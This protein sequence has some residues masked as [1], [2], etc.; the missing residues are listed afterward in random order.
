MRKVPVLAKG[1]KYAFGQ[2]LEPF[3]KFAG[4][5]IPGANRLSPEQLYRKYEMVFAA[6]QRY[7]RQFP[8]ERLRERVIPNRERVIRTLCYHIFRIG[9]AFLETWDGAEYGLKIAD[10]EPPESMQ[11][12]DDIAL[13]GASVWKRYEIWWAGLEDRELKRVLKT[14]YGDTPAH[15]V[16]ERCTWHSA[17]HCRQLVAVLERMGIQP[18]RPLTPDDLAGLPLPERLWE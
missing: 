9:E 12:G 15:Q 16:F 2:M 7:A 8:V 13:Y 17:Q 14:Y 1:D 5:T 6:G 11:T 18:D 10:N 3:A 4:L